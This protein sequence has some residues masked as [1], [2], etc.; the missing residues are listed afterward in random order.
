MNTVITVSCT[1]ILCVVFSVHGFGQGCSSWMTKSYSVY[2]SSSNPK[3]NLISTS[4]TVDGSSG[5]VCP[6]GCGCSGVTHTPRAYNKINTTGGYVNGPS[7]PYNSYISATNNQQ[8]VGVPGV[9]YPFTYEG[10]I[11]C[12]AVGTFFTQGGSAPP[13]AGFTPSSHNY[14][15]NP[16]SSIPCWI[17]RAFDAVT[18]RGTKH[19]AQDIIKDGG[20]KGANIA[21]GT[22]VYAAESGTVSQT[23][24]S[25][26]PAPWPTCQKQSPAPQ[27]NFVKVKGSD[28]YYT[29]YAHVKPS[30]ATGTPVSAGTQIGVTDNSGCQSNSHIHMTRRD[31]SGNNYNFHLPCG[32]AEPTTNFADGLIDDNVDPI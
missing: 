11:I 30:V 18:A 28:G 23:D 13:V 20:G 3:G 12:S 6:F 9:I 26:G 10:D 21:Y 4:V 2:Y 22:P 17:S 15:N 32:N 16:L 31:A 7:G 29:V 14:P 24:S 19:N 8:I 25:K 5:G 1:A 27:P